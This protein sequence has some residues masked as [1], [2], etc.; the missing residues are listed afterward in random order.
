MEN[1]KVILIMTDT[2]RWDFL[3]CS[4]NTGL[5]TPNLDKMAA[6]GTRY[7]YAY[8]TQPVC[9]P[10]RAGI[11]TGRYPHSCNGWTNCMALDST[12]RFIG[13]R[14]QDKGIRTCYIGKWHL[15]GTDYFG[16]SQCPAG[17]DPEYWFD[18]RNHLESLPD[19]EARKRSR[20]PAHLVPDP[21]INELYAHGVANRALDYIKRY[22]QDEFFLTVSF[23]EPHGP[24]HCPREFWEKYVD[25]KFPKDENVWDTL[26][27]KPSFQKSWAGEYL[28]ENK[29]ELEISYPYHFGCNEYADFEIGRVLDAIEAY[30]PDAVVIFTSDHGHM[31]MAHSLWFKGVC[32]Y[33][34]N[35]RIPF[36][37]KGKGIPKGL[38]DPEPVSHIN[39]APTIFELFGL[40][41]PKIFQGVSLV[42]QI[43]GKVKRVNDFVF[44]EWGRYEI[45]QDMFGGFFP[46]RM[47]FDGRYKLTIY[48]MSTDELY[49]LKEDPYEMRNLIDSAK[50]AEIRDRLH[51]AILDMMNST[52]DP[53][54][55]W[56]WEQR[57]WRKGLPDPSVRWKDGMTRQREDEDYEPRQLNYMNGLEME[58]STR[59]M[60][61][62]TIWC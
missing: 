1:R 60:L 29:D 16:N 49:D 13:Q 27:G 59:R 23:D 50:H 4:R 45:D 33:D 11:F 62:K 17:W 41:Q 7:E 9:Q 52:R 34:E 56:V 12:T 53:F 58:E 20:L 36:I 6:E 31:M 55:G 35:T 30:I 42:P 38:V 14:L 46:M 28:K 15:D 44:S 18:G 43:E 19:D 32:G 10:A 37:I 26:E 2:T 24:H 57:P 22:K 25:F 40:E 8:T 21:D 39:I 3:N 61:I 47:V 48:L 54:R 5:Q 51:D